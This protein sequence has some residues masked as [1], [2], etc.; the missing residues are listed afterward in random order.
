MPNNCKVRHSVS[1]VQ[2]EEAD[3]VNSIFFH[4]V[5]SMKVW[6]KFSFC[7]L[8]SQYMQL[9]IYIKVFTFDKTVHT[10]WYLC[11]RSFVTT[12]CQGYV[13]TRI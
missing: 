10:T 8:L 3:G 11:N 9:T 7:F 6:R 5:N 12:L 13:D 1:T 2:W 4:I